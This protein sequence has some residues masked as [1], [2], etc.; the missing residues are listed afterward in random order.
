MQ[1]LTF[2]S[3]ALYHIPYSYSWPRDVNAVQVAAYFNREIR[4]VRSGMLVEWKKPVWSPE[5]V[6]SNGKASRASELVS[7]DV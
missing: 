3:F 1:Q 6:D 5:G 7:I 2:A 4:Y